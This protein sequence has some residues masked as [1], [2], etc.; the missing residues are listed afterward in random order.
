VVTA[1]P[2]FAYEWTAQRGL[3]ARGEDLDL[4]NVVM[5][6]GSEPVNID[7]VRTFNK[8]FAP[9]GLPHTA[10]KPSY[11]IAEATLFVSTIDPTAE[12][13]VV[14]LDR[15]EL[16]AGHAVRIAA[17]GPNAVAQ[18]SCGHIARSQWAVIVN[19]DTRAEVPD[20]AARRRQPR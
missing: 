13:T 3:P 17:D 19:P 2:N 4:S 11:G 5:I 1:A 14:Y 8:A 20:G 10:F 18:V 9:Y 16:G 7:A 15:E 12:A 6:I